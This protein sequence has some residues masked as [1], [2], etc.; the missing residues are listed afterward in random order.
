MSR[1]SK[2]SPLGRVLRDIKKGI[3][4]GVFPRGQALPSA[5]NLAK[6]F[7]ADRG[8]VSRALKALEKDGTLIR[9][10]SWTLIVAEKEKVIEYI[11]PAFLDNTVVVER[12][13]DL[14]KIRNSAHGWSNHIDVGI[15][16]ELREHGFNVFS[17]NL[18]DF[19]N[20]TLT[21]FLGGLPLASIVHS[22]NNAY[23]A[24]N[25]KRFL[26]EVKTNGIPLVSYGNAEEVKD[27]DH[28]MVDQQYGAYLLTKKLIED[29]CKKILTLFPV[30]E[31]HYWPIE[32]YHGYE[33]AMKEAGLEPL[34]MEE[35]SFVPLD[36]NIVGLE[37]AYRENSKLF[38]GSLLHHI[39]ADNSIDAVLAPSDGRAFY[40]AGA[41]RLCGKEPGKDVVIAGFDN[42][43]QDHALREVEPCLPKY[44]IDKNNEGAGAEM[45]KL[46]IKRLNKELPPEPQVEML[47][48]NLIVVHSEN[49]TS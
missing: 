12:C 11:R 38:A 35:C 13:A 47:K 27:V 42:Y 45:V 34:P 40:V 6:E 15:I 7:H 48:P 23:Y 3:E 10:G 30:P 20:I 8:T 31:R 4:N 14:T 26:A 32:R 5:R 22:V 24:E 29:G 9:T 19:D 25:V 44:T 21:E 49:A 33:Q 39:L 37:R 43:W 46:L 28:V 16:T 1:T 17:I 41:I 36:Y 18:R 2:L